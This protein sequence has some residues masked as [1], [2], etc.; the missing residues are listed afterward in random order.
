MTWIQQNYDRFLL[1]VF[2]A[3]LLA[4]A[5]LL[6]NNAHNFHKV[7][8]SLADEVKQK[9][10]VPPV[11]VDAVNQ[12]QQKL[13]SP[14]QWPPRMID[15]TRL[16]VFVSVPYIAKTTVTADGRQIQELINPLDNSI[17]SDIHPPVTN[18]W[19]LDNKQDLLSP[20]VLEQDSD[21][22]GFSTLDEFNGKTDPMDKASHPPYYTKMVMTQLVKKPFRLRYD[23]KNGDSISINVIDVEDAPTLFLK[24]GDLIKVTKPQYKV[25]KFTPKTSNAK[26]YPE[27][28][29]EVTV[30]NQEN[31]EQ[32][33][34][35]KRV[36]VDSPTSFAVI[37]YQWTG[38]PFAVKKNAEFTLKPEDNVKYKCI[39]M[40]ENE[41]KI[42]KED[43]NKM[44]TVPRVATTPPK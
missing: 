23:A 13:T 25:V 3:A 4:C 34:L 15:G 7:F 38:K 1:A 22:D 36:E 8:L 33:V 2:A 6:F 39:D 19:L 20:N 43:E 28:V 32:I 5:G 16:P 44:I 18:K 31:H 17:G 35:P 9:D 41:V 29:S 42:L 37:L 26:G 21:G 11:Q 14:D 40:T 27:D 10:I 12:E 24:V 30:E